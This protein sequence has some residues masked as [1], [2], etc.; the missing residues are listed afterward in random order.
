MD[1]QNTQDKKLELTRIKNISPRAHKDKKDFM[2]Q[3]FEFF[4]ALW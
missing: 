1:K 3:I 2:M 4:V